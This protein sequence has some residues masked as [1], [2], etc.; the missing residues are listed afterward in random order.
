MGEETSAAINLLEKETDKT[1]QATESIAN[2]IIELVVYMKEI[3]QI[4]EIIANIS[5]Q[6]NL[7]AL[8]ASI[9]AA[10]AGQSEKNFNVVAN[11]VRKLA[12][13]SKSASAKINSIITS[14]S[15]KTRYIKQKT[16]STEEIVMQ[17]INAI[18][19]TYLAVVSIVEDMNEANDCI[20]SVVEDVKRLHALK[21][22]TVKVIENISEVSEE[23]AST[24]EEVTATTQEQMISMQNLL[25]CT[26]NINSIVNKLNIS[27]EVFQ[28]CD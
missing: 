7:L 8:N 27:M 14:L 10:R 19:N 17:Q 25:K 15:K 24:T 22:D 3:G 16:S 11:E 13:V 23:T 28:I 21:D 20:N 4:S 5:Q 2:S 9:E 18:K 26:E 6:T 1:K 12:E